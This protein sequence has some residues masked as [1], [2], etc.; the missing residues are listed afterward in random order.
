MLPKIN[1][2]LKSLK[3]INPLEFL[4]ANFIFEFKRNLPTQLLLQILA[5]EVELVTEVQKE[6]LL[7]AV[8]SMNFLP[9][10]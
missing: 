5:A 3:V 7:S 9:A 6:I 8:S 1:A 10:N 2:W 4:G